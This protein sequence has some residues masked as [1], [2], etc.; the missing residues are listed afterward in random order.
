MSVGTAGQQEPG[1]GQPFEV[2]RVE[3]ATL[4]A[5]VALRGEVGG[6]RAHVGTH[7]L[8]VQLVRKWRLKGHCA[9]ASLGRVQAPRV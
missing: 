7:R 9:G 2:R 1:R 3:C 6:N 4:Q 5:L 8:S